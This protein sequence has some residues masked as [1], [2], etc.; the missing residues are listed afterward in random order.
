M[1]EKAVEME[2]NDALWRWNLA[3]AYRWSSQ[4]DKAMAAYDKAIEVAFRNYEVNPQNAE[5]LG[6]LA[7]CYAK[8]GD[9]KQAVRFIQ[10]A[11]SIDQ[12][13]NALMYKEATIDALAGRI[14]EALASLGLALRNG[15]SLQE[16]KSDPE[17]QSLR[18]RPEF[19]KLL[20]ELATKSAN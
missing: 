7:I 18:A 17:L 5:N 10:R 11:R 4:R 15:Y 13:D 6:Y 14:S 8:K 12:K 2:P 16:A 9:D 19:N 20:A 3:D 1:F